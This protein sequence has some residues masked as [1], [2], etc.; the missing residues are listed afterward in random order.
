MLKNALQQPER[1]A[2]DPAEFAKL[3][4]IAYDELFQGPALRV[5]SHEL[6]SKPKMGGRVDVM[7]YKLEFRSTGEF[8]VAVTSGL[9]DYAMKLPKG[10]GVLRRELIQYFRDPRPQD[11]ARLHDM[12]WLPLAQRYSLDYFHT[13]GPHPVEWPGSI[14]LPSLV[15]NHAK[16]EMKLGGDE[17]KLL[18]HVPLTQSELDYKLQHGADALLGKLEECQLPWIFDP[19]TRV[20]MV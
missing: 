2:G 19:Q 16:F 13:V 10:A 15:Q 9:S 11:L 17:V 14:F 1:P 7:L 5:M 18:W 6:F 3:R 20:P 8:Q 12:A 4:A